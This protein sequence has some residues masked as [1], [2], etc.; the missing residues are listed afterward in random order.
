VVVSARTLS[1]TAPLQYRSKCP[2][3]FA[4]ETFGDMWSLLII[5]DIV[6]YKK[7]T[8]GEFLESDE[9][10]STNILADRL[11]RL[12][13]VGLLKKTPDKNDKRKDIYRLTQK[14]IDLYPMMLEMML[15]STKYNPETDEYSEAA[16]LKAAK[17]K[18]FYVERR[19]KE[20]SD[21][22]NSRLE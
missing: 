22:A 8:Y 2:V 7:S 12:V 4:L 19:M 16:V 11:S 17:D 13:Q 18:R 21:F 9:K 1:K 15:W 3:N 10:I 5:R 14:G 6:R 20:I